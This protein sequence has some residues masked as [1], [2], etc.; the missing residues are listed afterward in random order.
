MWKL[1]PL[2]FYVYAKAA[3]ASVEAWGSAIRVFVM[4][5]MALCFPAVGSG[6][7]GGCN[8]Y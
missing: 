8:L 5:L 2:M 1:S 7:N 3:L 4:S 6:K